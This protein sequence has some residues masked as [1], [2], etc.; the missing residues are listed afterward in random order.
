MFWE[1]T[2][3][4]NETLLNAVVDELGGRRVLE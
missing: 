4:R 2:A 1:I 3:D